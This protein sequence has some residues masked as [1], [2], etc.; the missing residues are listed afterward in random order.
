MHE[1]G[2]AAKVLNYSFLLQAVPEVQSRLTSSVHGKKSDKK[3][4][5]QTEE[6][7]ALQDLIGHAQ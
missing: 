3:S 6:T 1:L 5:S 7:S 4:T 2:N